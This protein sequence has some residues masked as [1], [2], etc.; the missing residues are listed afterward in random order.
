M[1]TIANLMQTP[2]AEALGWT[3]IHSLW[4]GLLCFLLGLAALRCVPVRYSEC[5]Y[6]ISLVVS[7]L[8]LVC[9]AVT[10]GITYTSATAVTAPE[11]SLVSLSEYSY[12]V[13]P[14]SSEISALVTPPV[15]WL[16]AHIGMLSAVW[17]VGALVFALRIISGYW[18]IGFIRKEADPVG[19]FWQGRVAELAAKLNVR[20]W[21]EVAQ[22]GL[23]TAPVVIGYLKPMI[24]VPVGMFSGLTTEQLEAIFVH[25]LMHIRRGDYIV[26]LIQTI[27]EA[28]YFFNPFAWLMSAAIRREREHCCDDG[29]VLNHGNP[30]AYVRALATLEEARLSRSG[31]ALS[32]AEDKNQLLKRIKRIMEKSVHRY[33]HRDRIV[34]ALLLVV[35][36][37]CASWLTIQSRDRNVA[38]GEAPTVITTTVANDTT[39]KE[40]KGAYYHYSVTTID[41]EVKEDVRVVEGY[42]NDGKF[43]AVAVDPPLP[44]DPIAPVD[45]FV[46]AIDAFAAHPPFEAFPHHLITPPGVSVP[47]PA[48]PHA[49]TAMPFIL[50]GFDTIP[51]AHGS[52]E[53]FGRVF[54]EEF[55]ERF[56][57]FFQQNE[58]GMKELM[59]EMETR[60][61]D[62]EFLS[63]KMEGL[64][65][66]DELRA[67]DEQWARMA[68]NLAKRGEEMQRAMERLEAPR[69][70]REMERLNREMER[71]D[72]EMKQMEQRLRKAHEQ[73]RE[74][75]IK[76]GYLKKDERIDSIQ[77]DHDAMEINGKKIKPADAKRYLKLL[78]A[79]EHRPGPKE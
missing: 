72:A 3:M 33:S 37:M 18:Y 26:N 24:L 41:D 52:W 74:E 7:A 34:P 27:F 2:A 66:L 8:M 12:P 46:G 32:L 20:S 65:R 49:F 36:L 4:Q 31:M 39:G 70:E 76:D 11:S 73:V 25:E 71:M 64:A 21:V 47:M 22:S 58:S 29:V 59:K 61:A 63:R 54:E 60:F 55:R 53:E 38:A 28:I 14:S 23:I 78:E 75:A 13:I 67:R 1:E 30:M 42:S 5:R 17:M 68:E 6:A 79:V 48:M 62:E 16:G 56:E 57:D 45:P 69:M 35:G 10:F 50:P 77:I 40:K 44:V 15:A 51:D 19:A 9:S 43:E